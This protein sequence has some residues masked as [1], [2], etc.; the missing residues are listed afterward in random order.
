MVKGG[1]EWAHGRIGNRN[2]CEMVVCNPRREDL[3]MER[4]KWKKRVLLVALLSPLLFIAIPTMSWA[5]LPT[6][7]NALV[8]LKGG[9]AALENNRSGEAFTDCFAKGSPACNAP[10]ATLNDD[11]MGYNVGAGLDLPIALLPWGHV[12]IGE[13]DVGFSRFSTGHTFL[14]LIENG[15]TTLGGTTPCGNPRCAIGTKPGVPGRPQLPGVRKVRVSTVNAAINP[16]YRMDTLFGEDRKFR[17]WI[18]PVGWEFQIF[19]PPP[20]SMQ[21]WEIGGVA[22]LGMDV[23]VWERIWVGVEG[24]YHYQ[25]TDNT[26]F[27]GNWVTAGGYVG[28]SW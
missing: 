10:G 14:Q 28:I 21:M 11:T 12:I 8:K 1:K 5:Q 20:N 4:A 16:K 22:G 9:F 6:E 2:L 24:R 19:S 15:P 26:G 17:P 13:L 25:Y 27:N 7:I 23:H 3:K 18:I